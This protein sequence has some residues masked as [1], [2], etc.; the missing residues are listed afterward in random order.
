MVSELKLMGL[1]ELQ[2]WLQKTVPHPIDRIKDHL[3]GLASEDRQKLLSDA[4]H[5]ANNWPPNVGSEEAAEYL[6][7]TKFGPVETM[8][9]GLKQHQPDITKDEAFDVVRALERFTSRCEEVINAYKEV[10]E[11][12]VEKA[13]EGEYAPPPFEPP[14]NDGQEIIRTIYSTLFGTNL[15]LYESEEKPILKKA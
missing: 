15:G 8:F 3:D 2:A 4:R 6:L 10:Y 12:T 7:M 5:E 13:K 1:L 9:V 11:R 14:P